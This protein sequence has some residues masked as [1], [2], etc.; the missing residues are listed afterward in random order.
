MQLS[1]TIYISPPYGSPRGAPAPWDPRKIRPDP[2]QTLFCITPRFP[3]PIPLS[4]PSLT[5]APPFGTLL[6]ATST[7]PFPSSPG[8][9]CVREFSLAAA[10]H[11]VLTYVWYRYTN[12]KRYVQS[13]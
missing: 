13:L 1:H 5:H 9:W 3:F 7:S 4:R 10:P 8:E 12:V 6:P 2:G 11:N